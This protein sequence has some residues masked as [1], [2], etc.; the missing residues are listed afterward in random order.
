VPWCTRRCG[1]P[2]GRRGGPG[3]R[4][5]R[6]SA[7]WR[8]YMFC[9]T[10]ARTDSL[11]DWTVARTSNWEIL[12][13]YPGL[14]SLTVLIKRR[15]APPLRNARPPDLDDEFGPPRG[16]QGRPDQLVR[17]GLGRCGSGDRTM[18]WGAHRAALWP[19]PQHCRGSRVGSSADRFGR[20]GLRHRFPAR[21]G[22]RFA[23]DGCRHRTCP[24]APVA[25]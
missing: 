12:V 2:T 7:S 23:R 17:R 24:W 18:A 6:R 4:C 5:W 16:E 9:C 15:C 19:E 22:I 1:S 11:I 8:R 10:D 20:W 13:K 14:V 25:G 3:F 21:S